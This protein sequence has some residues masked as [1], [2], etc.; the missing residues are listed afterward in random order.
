MSPTV[1]RWS[2][3][4]TRSSTSRSSSR[5]ATRVSRWLPL[6]RIS[7]FKLLDLDRVRLRGT[8]DGRRVR[9]GG[10]LPFGCLTRR[11]R[12]EPGVGKSVATACNYM[13]LWSLRQLYSAGGYGF[14]GHQAGQNVPRQDDSLD[15]ARSLADLA[16][17]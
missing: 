13:Q 16:D 8:I 6:I 9:P 1:R 10:Q 7:R 5:I 3:R 11:A 15:F 12:N 2:G 14:R 4:S 17:L